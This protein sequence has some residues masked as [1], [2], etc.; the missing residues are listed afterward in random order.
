MPTLDEIRDQIASCDKCELCKGRN[1]TVPGEGN[2]EADIVLV[3]EGP[4]ENEDEEGKPFVGRSG[5]LLTKIL[6]A[7][8]VEREEVFVTNVVKCRPPN[9]RDPKVDEVKACMPY[10]VE[11]VRAINPSLIIALGKAAAN[12]LQGTTGVAISKLRNRKRILFRE[13]GL[14]VRVAA[15]YHP[16]YVQRQQA[17]GSKEAGRNVL[18]DFQKALSIVKGPVEI[19]RGTKAKRAKSGAK[20]RL[21]I[22]ETF[23]TPAGDY[24]I[25]EC[26]TCKDP[27][28]DNAIWHEP[29]DPEAGAKIECEVCGM[30]ATLRAKPKKK[31]KSNGEGKG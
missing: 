7:Y 1:K 24:A 18:D 21:R 3:G 31:S 20:T 26:S 12:A 30:T 10:L 9:N 8:D 16:A 2:P 29:V 27:N 22:I 11:Q 15:T 23:S 25:V 4:G 14:N 5:D 6:K 28:G 17:M 13:G 19:T